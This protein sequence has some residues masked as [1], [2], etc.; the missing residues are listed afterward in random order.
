MRSVGFRLLAPPTHL[1]RQDLGETWNSEVRKQHAI[2]LLIWKNV[3]KKRL[4]MLGINVSSTNSQMI[5][6]R[7]C[8]IPLEAST[9]NKR[10]DQKWPFLLPLKAATSASTKPQKK[11][12]TSN[13]QCV[14]NVQCMVG[15]ATINCVLKMQPFVSIV[16]KQNVIEFWRSLYTFTRKND[17][18]SSQWNG[19]QRPFAKLG[20]QS[21]TTNTMI[22]TVASFQFGNC[23]RMVQ[24]KR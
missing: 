12:T 2:F 23:K 7:H 5:S 13:I 19:S 22:Q 6:I 4:V 24:S 17:W 1:Q 11:N 14:S 9:P 10:N 3:Q 20:F 15:S 16:P 18:F 21:A 8:H